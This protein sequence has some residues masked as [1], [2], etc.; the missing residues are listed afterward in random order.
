MKDPRFDFTIFVSEPPRVAPAPPL[1]DPFL[2]YYDSFG[3]TLRHAP[4]PVVMM[5]NTSVDLTPFGRSIAD[6]LGIHYAGGMEHGM[7]ALGKALWWHE[8][9]A[10]AGERL[11]QQ[12][13]APVITLN[14]RPSGSWP[15]Y[16]ARA[17]LQAHG[18]PVAPGK[19]VTDEEEA[20]AAAQ[21]FGFPVAMKIQSSEILHK[22]DIGGVLL[23]LTSADEVRQGF[24]SIMH[25]ATAQT[26]PR[27]VDGILISPM[28]PAGIELLVGVI[29][30]PLWGQ[31]LAVGLG[32]ILVEILKDTSIRVLPVQR[33]EIKEMLLEL[34][35]AAI[36]QGIRG[37][38]PVNMDALVDSIFRVAQ[39]SQGLK[40]NLESLEINP[41]LLYNS[42]L[43]ALD[44]LMTWK[45]K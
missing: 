40:D 20:V 39:I 45:Q 13:P 16:K 8:V 15:E 32:G 38:A 9:V 44:V 41:F 1:L 33:D 25:N 7:K 42:H 29:Q 10:R 22:S 4:R 31:V 12:E 17:F 35:G 26:L 30:D 6:R 19:L 34:H 5:S 3:E 28:R 2:E 37:Q 36:F 14:E 21:A 18:V 24:R 11:Q 27:A 23:N 43:E